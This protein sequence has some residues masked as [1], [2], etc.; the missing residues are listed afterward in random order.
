VLPAQAQQAP[1]DQQRRMGM[2]A[3]CQKMMTD[4]KSGQERL[5]DLS[6]E[7][8]AATGQEKIDRM[9]AVF[10]E[11]VARQNAMHAHMTMMRHQSATHGDAPP[12]PPATGY[13]GHH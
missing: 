13:E 7:M 2:M 4:M 11:L 9:A 3:D 1:T 10:T 5:D 6:T 8:N 12:E